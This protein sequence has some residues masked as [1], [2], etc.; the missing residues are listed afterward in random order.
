VLLSLVV[1][2][3]SYFVLALAYNLL[4]G[5]G[6]GVKSSPNMVAEFSMIDVRFWAALV[7]AIVLALLPRYANR[8][9]IIMIV[10]IHFRFTIHIFL[11]AFFPS[12]TLVERLKQRSVNQVLDPSQA[13]LVQRVRDWWHKKEKTVS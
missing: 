5:P 4:V 12:D 6:W 1:S 13:P 3:L 11:N 7:L 10:T 8:A 2:V 9:S